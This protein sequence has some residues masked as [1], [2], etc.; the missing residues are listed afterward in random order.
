MQWTR[1]FFE[2]QFLFPFN[3]LCIHFHLTLPIHND[4]VPNSLSLTMIFF[5][6]PT[7]FDDSDETEIN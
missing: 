7:G 6:I 1:K 4:V 2:S 5:S 3:T